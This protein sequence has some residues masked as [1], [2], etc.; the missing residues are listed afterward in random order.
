MTILGQAGSNDEDD[1]K[2]DCFCGVVKERLDGNEHSYFETISVGDASGYGGGACVVDENGF[3]RWY[4]CLLPT[5]GILS[6]ND[7]EA[8]E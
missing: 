6:E 3:Q 1:S 5:E 2:K 7:A 4:Q 8:K